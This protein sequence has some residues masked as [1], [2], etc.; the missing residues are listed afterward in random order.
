VLCS[1]IIK[2]KL[3]LTGKA[4]IKSDD[5][6]DYL[7]VESPNP[8]KSGDSDDDFKPKKVIPRASTS[9]NKKIDRRV[10]SSD[11]DTPTNKIDVWCEVFVE[12]LEQWIPV[13]VIKGKIHCAEHNYVSF[14][15]IF[16]LCPLSHASKQN[17]QLAYLFM[18]TTFVLCPKG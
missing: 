10:L 16:T 11:E 8:K 4:K 15:I 12:E 14:S 5:D 9:K 18:L 17:F 13:E 3:S 1:I 6:S 2:N 7:P